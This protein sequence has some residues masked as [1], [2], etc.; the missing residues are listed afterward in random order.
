MKFKTDRP[1]YILFGL[2]A[3]I[4]LFMLVG[5]SSPTKLDHDTT[6]PISTQVSTAGLPESGLSEFEFEVAAGAICGFRESGVSEEKV[7]DLLLTGTL[8]KHWDDEEILI[9]T[10]IA[11]ANECPEYRSV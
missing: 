4:I 11:Y 10:D 9:F 7:Y 8:T 6:T 3:A 5:C 1:L 2:L